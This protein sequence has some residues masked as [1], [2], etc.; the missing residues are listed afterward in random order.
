MARRPFTITWMSW[1]LQKST[2][3]PS[4]LS[5]RTFG[6]GAQASTSIWVRSS[7]V[8]IRLLLMFIPTATTTSS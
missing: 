4:K 8:N 5:T 2:I 6:H 7:K 3:S 1:A